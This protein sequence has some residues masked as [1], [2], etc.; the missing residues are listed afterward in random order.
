MHSMPRTRHQQCQRLF[1]DRLILISGLAKKLA[2]W[3]PCRLDEIR[4]LKL[5]LPCSHHSQRRLLDK[6]ISAGSIRPARVIEM[7]GS[8]GELWGSAH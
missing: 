7:D 3:K 1:N 8:W 6:H 2:P 4:D 5:I